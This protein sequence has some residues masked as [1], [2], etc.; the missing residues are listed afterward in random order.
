MRRRNFLA[1][2]LSPLVSNGVSAWA[3]EPDAQTVT[4][5]QG[6][7]LHDIY[8]EGNGKDSAESL[9]AGE[10]A[11]FLG[12]LTSDHSEA[13]SSSPFNPNADSIAAHFLV[14][15][16]PATEELISQ[17][18]L[19]DPAHRNP[20]AYVVRAINAGGKTKVVFLGGTGIATL[21]AVY[22]YLEKYC[23]CGFYWDGDHVP[24]R[25]TLPAQGVNITAE[26]YFRER[27]CMNLTH[28]WYTAPWWEWQ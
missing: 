10:L 6:V 27:M 15:R 8:L 14:G 16:T 23:G 4:P 7:K 24:R 21:Y 2:T 26:P 19:E 20:E 3:S 18:K 28:Y 9:A 1:A 11:Q 22:H 5:Q 13:M 12:R 17:G 25:E